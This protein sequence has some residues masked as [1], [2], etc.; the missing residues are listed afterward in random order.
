MIFEA[1]FPEE[2]VNDINLASR[3]GGVTL[4]HSPNRPK[5]REGAKTFLRGEGV[6][7][8]T[9]GI[10]FVLDSFGWQGF[11]FN[12]IRQTTTIMII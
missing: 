5:I 8:G 12:L 7:G 9:Q 2:G 6:G 3:N 1:L 4:W 11:I 10:L